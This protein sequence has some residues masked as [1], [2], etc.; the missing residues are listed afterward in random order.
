MKKSNYI[1]SFLCALGGHTVG[2]IMLLLFSSI[3]LLFNMPLRY[4]A[5][6]SFSAMIIGA[7]GCGFLARINSDDYVCGILSSIIFSFTILLVSFFGKE[8]YSLVLKLGIVSL[9]TVICIVGFFV[10]HKK[11]RS[12]RKRKFNSSVIARNI[13]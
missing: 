5:T 2:I 6:F 10:P 9:V 8:N 1:I 11:K 7:L 12:V 13:K 3:S 4:S